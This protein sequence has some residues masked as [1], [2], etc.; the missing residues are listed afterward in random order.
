MGKD[1]NQDNLDK[2]QPA[3]NGP[4]V[5]AEIE[6]EADN[7]ELLKCRL[8]EVDR[9]TLEKAL[10]KMGVAGGDPQIISAGELILLNC[11]VDGDDEIRKNESYRVAASL[12]AFSLIEMKNATL[13]KI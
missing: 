6:V 7:G 8:K 12:Q 2:V 1:N 5:V 10:G 9:R 13:K 4:K 3:A 11:W